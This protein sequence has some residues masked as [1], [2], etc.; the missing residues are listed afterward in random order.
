MYETP[1]KVIS[2]FLVNMYFLCLLLTMH[3]KNSKV[4]Y[5]RINVY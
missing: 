2:S 5:N 4:V 1:Y 3:Y